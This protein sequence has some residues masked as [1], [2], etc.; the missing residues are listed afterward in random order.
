MLCTSL[1]EYITISLYPY[2]CHLSVFGFVCAH[3]R[4]CVSVC[5]CALTCTNIILIKFLPP[6]FTTTNIAHNVFGNSPLNKNNSK[7]L[8]SLLIP[9]EWERRTRRQLYWN[10]YRH[11]TNV[12]EIHIF[13]NNCK[14]FSCFLFSSQ[15]HFVI[16]ALLLTYEFLS[17][18]SAVHDNTDVE[19]R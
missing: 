16:V 3:A 2:F 17:V 11:V 14:F 5:V 1:I 6:Y 19:F 12:L 18:Y 10:E 15:N 9:L 7:F 13:I 4:V 8:N